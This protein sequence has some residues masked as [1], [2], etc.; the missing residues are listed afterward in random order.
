MARVRI[1]VLILAVCGVAG[2]T[3]TT[4]TTDAAPS[5]T[6]LAGPTSPT[7]GVASARD[8][9]TFVLGQR[10]ELPT[11]AL[12]CFLDAVSAGQPV[13]L[14]ET[15]PTVEGDPIPVTFSA[16]ARGRVEVITDSRKDRFGSGTVDRITCTAP[17][18]VGGQLHFA[19]CSTPTLVE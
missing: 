3:P 4:G 11:S 6:A 7:V 14:N 17:S 9:G 13:V 16:D 15:R 12:R 10:E 1:V 8:C 2:C 5:A 18:A 19:T